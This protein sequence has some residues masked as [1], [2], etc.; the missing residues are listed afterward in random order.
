MKGS[1]R[2]TVI[3]IFLVFFLLYGCDD[4]A[5][6]VNEAVNQKDPSLCNKLEET[7]VKENCVEEVAQGLHDPAACSFSTNANGCLTAYAVKSRSTAPC[8]LITDAVGKYA[9]IAG[10]TG[11]QTGRSIET[12]LAE[13][14]NK[15]VLDL[16][17]GRCRKTTYESCR[18][19]CEKTK[20][21][22]HVYCAE[23]DPG[24]LDCYIPYDLVAKNCL[25]DCDWAGWDCENDCRRATSE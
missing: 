4:K 22:W 11:D 14:R 2:M 15:N 13:W 7:V 9:C 8:D 23:H 17:L 19:L 5:S 16:C 1:L 6:A 12:L 18:P 3:A 20:E 10:V 21:E 24:N 25:E